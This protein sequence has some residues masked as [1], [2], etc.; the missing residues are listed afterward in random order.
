MAI[1]SH[2]T[3]KDIPLQQNPNFDPVF[4]KFLTQQNF[5]HIFEVGTGKG[6]FTLFLRDILP[7]AKILTYD[8]EYRLTYETLKQNNIDIRLGNIFDE[9]INNTDWDICYKQIE[10]DTV[11]NSPAPKL[12]DEYAIQFL[13]EPGK[14]LILCDGGHKVGEF[15]C[16]ASL[17]NPGDFIMAH[18]YADT[19]DRYST[20]LKGTYWDWCEIEEKYISK[21]SEEN[22]LVFYNQIIFETIAWVCKT[23]MN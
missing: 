11:N 2:I 10:A 12:I 21:A 22:N 3:Y 8:V 7:N 23:K 18:D 6:G 17:L 5:T 1:E 15:N 14:K 4:K 9:N 16:L 20:F 19:Y 13:K